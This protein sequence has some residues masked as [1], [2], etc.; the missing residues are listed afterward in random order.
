MLATIGLIIAIALLVV[1]IIKGIDMI[2][3]TVITAAII[4]VTSGLDL[5]EGFLTTFS[6]GAGGFVASWFF[7][8]GAWRGL[9]SACSRN[10][11]GNK[12]RPDTDKE[13][14]NENGRSGHPDLYIFHHSAWYQRLYY[15]ICSLP[16]CR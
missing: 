2:T 13:A 11:S 10:R 7:N 4:L 8:P 14:G 16:H 12:N 1:M 9:W 3:A 6:G 15:G 5:K